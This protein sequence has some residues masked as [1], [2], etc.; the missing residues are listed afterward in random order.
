MVQ[1]IRSA[2]QEDTQSLASFDD[3][4]QHSSSRRRFI[5]KAVSDETC[6][7]AVVDDRNVGYAILEYTFYNHGFV[8]MLMV[9]PTY[10]RMGIGVALMQHLESECKTRKIFTSTNLS[11]LAMQALLAKLGYERSGIIHNLD[12]ND[13]EL[14]Y[15]KERVITTDTT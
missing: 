6:F 13:P 5:E 3:V 2:S 12:P 8:S 7:V 11:N 10:R 1:Q 4:A 15:M 9:D 14:V